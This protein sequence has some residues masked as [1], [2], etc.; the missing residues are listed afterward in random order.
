MVTRHFV[1]QLL[2]QNR[3]V[4]ER[5]GLLGRWHIRL[6]AP[7]YCLPL[8]LPPRREVE[9]TRLRLS[10]LL[11]QVDRYESSTAGSGT[12]LP[13]RSAR[14]Y[15]GYRIPDAVVGRIGEVSCITRASS[16]NSIDPGSSRVKQPALLPSGSVTRVSPPRTPRRCM[17]MTAT[18]STPSRWAPSGG[19]S[20]DSVCPITSVR[21]R[22]PV[23][24]AARCGR[25]G[26]SMPGHCGPPIRW[27]RTDG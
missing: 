2:Q 11:C 20:T 14:A 19:G 7:D 26:A 27:A 4:D 12:H 1:V 25:A 15:R 17:S 24:T 23:R 8:W 22:A 3:R 10:R 18:K 5:S 21:P 9:P 16:I 13:G 6:E